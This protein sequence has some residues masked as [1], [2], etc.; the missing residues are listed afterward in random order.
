VQ[1]YCPD[2]PL[3]LR[4]DW[5]LTGWSDVE[6][7]S[8]VYVGQAAA[9]LA[10]RSGTLVPVTA[11]PACLVPGGIG[12]SDRVALAPVL[13][14]WSELAGA[15]AAAI[16][17]RAWHAAAT[18]VD[19]RIPAVGRAGIT[20][21]QLAEL[22]R[23]L[24]ERS[25]R[26]GDFDPGQRAEELAREA[27]TGELG[28]CVAATVGAG[29]GTTP[30]GDDVICGVLAGLD[31]LGFEGAHRRLGAA[32]A[33]LLSCTTRSSR[34]LLAAAAAGRYTEGLI[35][36]AAALVSASAPAVRTALAV[37]GRWGASSGLD[38]ATGFAAAIRA[39]A[40]VGAGAP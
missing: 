15:T 8:V 5:A 6:A 28:A 11:G 33:T 3:G 37:L 40:L 2:P 30:A 10:T 4:R 25:F 35:G 20:A 21:A 31:L 29:L 14:R 27:H 36:L 16:N 26:A 1:A 32:V 18:P 12:V 22:D 23:G 13:A 9:V 34:H 38:Q 24:P 7:L 19:L 39:G 17:L